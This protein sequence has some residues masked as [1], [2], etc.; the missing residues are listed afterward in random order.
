[1]SLIQNGNYYRLSDPFVDPYA[2]WMFG[3]EDRRQVLLNVVMLEMHGN[4]TIC[5]V[6]LKGLDPD[7][8]Y[9]DTDTG[10]CYYG[11]ALMEAGI[12]MPA[13][14]GEYLSYQIEFKIE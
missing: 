1:M 8:V 13:Q 3:T 11:S 5:Y 2:A 6:K 9:Q 4:M 12:P 14:M 7:A 10:N